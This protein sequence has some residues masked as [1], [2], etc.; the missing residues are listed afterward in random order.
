MSTTAATGV[1][2][3]RRAPRARLRSFAWW[4]ERHALLITALA[5]VGVISLGTLPQHITQDSWLALIGGRYI[6]AHGIPHHDTLFIMTHGAHWIDQQWLAQL[7][8]YGLDRLGGLPLYGLVYVAITILG[9]TLAVAA[10]RALGGTERHVLWVL[11]IA[12]GL[13]FAGAFN[14]RT[15]GFALPLFSAVLWLL[16]REFRGAQDRRVYLVFPLLVLWANLH[17]SVT[18]AVAL[19]MLCGTVL[20][21][22][23]IRGQ[24][25]RP[26]LRR[27]R[28]RSVALI[29]GSPLCLLVTPYGLQIIRYYHET[30]LNPAFGKVVTEWQ[31]VTTLMPLAIPFF[32]LA[33]AAVYVSGRAGRRMP[34]FDQIA[35]IILCAAAI[36][37]IRNVT[38]FGLGVTILLP[39]TLSRLWPIRKLKPRRTAV[40]LM[41]GSLALVVVTAT[42]IA[43]V[44]RPASWFER[45]YNGRA[46][47]AVERLAQ[48]SPDAK[49]YADNRYADWLL[50]QD[51]RL[52]DRIAYDIRFELL[53]SGQIDQIVNATALP[54]PGQHSLL[55]Q[56]RVL[57]LDP[58]N[59]TVTRQILARSGT[60]LLLRSKTADVATWTPPS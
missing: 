36:F 15:Q 32:L 13:Y 26:A 40:N 56:Y 50:W 6:V 45:F 28:V 39:S 47:T 29:L 42:A 4:L 17:G 34:A 8:L 57:V 5:A 46:V 58:S 35:L 51:P 41:L 23:D 11:P 52:G 7:A 54:L 21:V 37:A 49:I 20:A 31:P 60:H 55:D 24:A 12:T 27:I 38:W 53:T 14:V 19:A 9:L 3:V 33:L 43:V 25:G 18:L 16:A 10:G 1:A 22:D 59:G 44:V 48:T 2:A 30:L